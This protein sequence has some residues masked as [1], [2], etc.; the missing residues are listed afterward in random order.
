MEE[1]VEKLA[2]FQKKYLRGLAHGLKPVVIVGQ[3]GVSPSL[4]KSVNEALMVHELIK[5]KFNEYKEK[6]Q[7]KQLCERIQNE[8]GCE[9]VGMIGH[10]AI[11]FRRHPDPEKRK[12]SIPKRQ[13]RS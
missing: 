3:S 11:F 12:I 8:T 1:I 6:E 7:K 9:T 10:T 2:G 4:V 5:I 13:P